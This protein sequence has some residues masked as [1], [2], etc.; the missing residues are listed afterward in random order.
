[1]GGKYFLSKD[2]SNL[3]KNYVS[4]DKV[5]GYLEP[6]CGALNVLVKMNE[7]KCIGSDYHP[8]L[9]ELWKDLQKFVNAY[10][11]KSEKQT[12]KVIVVCGSAFSKDLQIAENKAVLS[13][14]LKIADITQHTLVRSEK[15]THKERNKTVTKSYDMTADNQLFEATIVGYRV[16]HKKF[17]REG[18]G[19][20]AM[21]IIEY[22]LT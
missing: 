3:M 17:V 4:K 9:I 15:I 2:I 8:D 5:D 22:K 19:W 20:R 10:C 16:V 11:N 7:Y 1:M 18:N 14:K 13:A 6:F 12:D 21:V